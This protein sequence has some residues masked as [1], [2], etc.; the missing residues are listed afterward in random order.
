MNEVMYGQYLA[1]HLD[2]SKHPA[3]DS[4]ELFLGVYTAEK[5][6]KVFVAGENKKKYRVWKLGPRNLSMTVMAVWG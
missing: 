1:Q 6:R 3:G 5:V 2:P 4:Y